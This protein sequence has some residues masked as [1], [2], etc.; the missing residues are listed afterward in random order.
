MDIDRVLRVFRL[1][2]MHYEQ[3]PKQAETLLLTGEEKQAIL[4]LKNLIEE[5]ARLF[6]AGKGV[7]TD[8]AA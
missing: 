7:R 5:Y 8:K 6:E 3:D 1:Y 2:C 4:E